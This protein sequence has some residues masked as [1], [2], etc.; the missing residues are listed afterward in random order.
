M[1][2]AETSKPQSEIIGGSSVKPGF[3][4][5]LAAEQMKRLG[6]LLPPPIAMPKPGDLELKKEVEKPAPETTHPS[7]QNSFFERRSRLSGQRASKT[8][9]GV[10]R[11]GIGLLEPRRNTLADDIRTRGIPQGWAISGGG[12]LMR[13]PYASGIYREHSG[14]GPMVTRYPAR[15]QHR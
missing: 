2:D 9:G 6:I 15:T 10:T 13:R 8:R 11:S 5:I 4:I 14:G 7:S 1:V 3:A 12:P